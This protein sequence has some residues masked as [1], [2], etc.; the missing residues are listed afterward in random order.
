M[1]LSFCVRL[2]A[3]NP[4]AMPEPHPLR[5]MQNPTF[6]RALVW[7]L[8]QVQPYQL[9]KELPSTSLEPY[10]NLGKRQERWLRG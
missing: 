1:L 9:W 8:D 6:P 5:L 10:T 3:E 4:P 2:G 7:A